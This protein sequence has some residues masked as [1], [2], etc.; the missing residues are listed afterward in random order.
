M[1]TLEQ[2]RLTL[3]QL[4]FTNHGSEEAHLEAMDL[5]QELWRFA[6]EY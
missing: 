5:I 2:K 1:L 3:E 4:R 6:L